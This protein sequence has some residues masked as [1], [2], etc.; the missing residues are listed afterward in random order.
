MNLDDLTFQ[1]LQDPRVW[2]ILRA[3]RPVCYVPELNLY[4][5]TRHT[6]VKYLLDHASNAQTLWPVREFVPE[7]YA[8]MGPLAEVEKVTAAGETGSPEYERYRKALVATF[9]YHPNQ[10]PPWEP[11]IT[12]H[13]TRLVGNLVNRRAYEVDLVNEFAAMLSLNVVADVLGL[14][15]DPDER[16]TVKGWADGQIAGV[17]GD[18]TPEEQVATM[19]GLVAWWEHCKKFVDGDLPPDS[20][21]AKM[22]AW[23]DPSGKGLTLNEIASFAFNIMVAGYETTRS[24]IVNTMEQAM[25]NSGYMAM[26]YSGGRETRRFVEAVNMFDPSIIGWLRTLLE[27]YK[28]APQGARVLLSI[29]SANRDFDG[30]D[31]FSLDKPLVR[32]LAFGATAHHCIGI[33]LARAETEYST[34]LLARAFPDMKPVPGTTRQLAN[35]IGFRAA[36]ERRVL[37]NP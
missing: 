23:K 35:N 24:L 5:V 34:T 10:I 20:F 17:W 15:D 9:P 25:V 27:D 29:G 14:P 6:D 12:K 4:M 36:T 3:Q 18:P 2:A 21:T 37:L 13:T 31:R 28:G 33:S 1:E 11:S 7:A 26:L 19:K 8:V 16:L 32:S 30:G 22:R